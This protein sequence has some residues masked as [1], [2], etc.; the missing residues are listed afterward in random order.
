MERKEYLTEEN[1]EKGKKKIKIIAIIILLLGLLLGGSLI[2]LGIVKNNKIDSNYSED[3][4]MKISEK[5]NAEKELLENRKKELKDKGITYNAFTEYDDGESYELKVITKALDPSFDNCAFDECKNNSI[6]SKY[7][8]L[9]KQ[10]EELNND[11]FFK[12]V[13]RFLPKNQTLICDYFN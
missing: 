11:T 5:L 2:G 1:Y 6:T 10:L 13:K 3:S 8:S 4:K 9:K 12:R 7:C